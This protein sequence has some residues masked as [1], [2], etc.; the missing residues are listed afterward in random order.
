MWT[1]RARTSAGRHGA[2]LPTTG[3]EA[4]DRRWAA[5]NG[6]RHEASAGVGQTR[7][8][9]VPIPGVWWP[10]HRSDLGQRL[11]ASADDG[12]EAGGRLG[13]VV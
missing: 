12:I 1:L 2:E 11:D 9:T 10:L 8:D 13:R 3:R 5:G 6:G 4:N 7:Q